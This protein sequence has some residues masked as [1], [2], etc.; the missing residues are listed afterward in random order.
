M[1]LTVKN[2]KSESHLIEVEPIST[3]E[4]LQNQ[5]A[6]LFNCSITQIKLI[7]KSKQLEPNQTIEFC[8]IHE[9]DSLVCIILKVG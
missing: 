7:H 4:H 2:L 8:Q 6:S 3:I 1:K 9:N 5:L